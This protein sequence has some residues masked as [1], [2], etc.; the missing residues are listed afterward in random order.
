[1][2][3]NTQYVSHLVSSILSLL[4]IARIETYAG[5]ATLMALHRSWAAYPNIR[6]STQLTVT[7]EN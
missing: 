3:Y 5:Y 7:P 1:M 6:Y 4:S 2:A